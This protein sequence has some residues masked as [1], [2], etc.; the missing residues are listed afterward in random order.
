[1]SNHL[2]VT[3]QTIFRAGT[4]WEKNK[5]EIFLSLVMRRYYSKE[6][7][8]VI[9]RN[10]I[11]WYD[12]KR[13]GGKCDFNVCQTW[14]L[15]DKRMLDAADVQNRLSLGNFVNKTYLGKTNMKKLL[16]LYSLAFYA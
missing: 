12:D 16:T 7:M 8:N 2:H 10:K 3:Y 5:Y 9:Y 4:Y 14:R 11:E 1:M 15:W 6:N 13:E